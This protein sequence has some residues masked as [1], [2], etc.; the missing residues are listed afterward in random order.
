VA[1]SKSKSS[2]KAAAAP[3]APSFWTQPG[4]WLCLLCGIAAITAAVWL[5]FSLPDLTEREEYQFSLLETHLPPLSPWVPQTIL[6]QVI[7]NGEL[8]E[9]VSLLEPGLSERVAQAWERHPWV[10]SVKSVHITRQRTLEVDV[11]F[12]TPI[13]FVE[14][15][16][17]LYPIDTEG[18]LLPPGDFELSDISRLPRIQ[19]VKTLPKG[20]TGTFWQDP[21]VSSAATLAALLAPDLNLETYWNRFGFK[22]VVAP[23]VDPA[24]A[25]PEQLVFEIETNGGSRVLWGKIPGVD[26]LEPTSNVKLAR[27]QDY[28]T[29]F[30]GLDGSNGPQKIDIRLFDGISLQ[31]LQENRFR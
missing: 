17:G 5:P 19:G 13:A 29:R 15:P 20:K 27:L 25:S 12:R 28:V 10:K 22:A 23:D 30:G 8:P 16:G 2:S 21:V 3:A 6:E 7:K 14:V 4:T 9:R 24:T 11:E 18:V 26:R 31:P 1:G